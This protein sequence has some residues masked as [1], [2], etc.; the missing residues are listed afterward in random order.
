[1]FI[2]S[3]NIYIKTSFFSTIRLEYFNLQAGKRASIS[4]NTFNNIA[5]YKAKKSAVVTIGTFDGVHHGH[6]KILKRV[7]EIAQEQSLTSILL[8]FFPHPRMVLQPD[9]NLQ[10]IN[11]I[12][13]RQQLI[14]TNGIENIITHPFSPEFART[15]AHDY[16]KDILVDQLNAAVVVIGYDH[17]FGRNRAASIN[18]LEEYGKEYGFEVIQISK[19]DVEE[20]TVSSTKIRNAIEAGDMETT[21]NYL[22]RPF[23]IQ[24]SIVQGKA[25]GRTIN[26]PTANLKIAETYK[27]SPKNGV[28]ITSSIINN[29]RVYG[30]TNIG[31]NP[32]VTDGT[33]KTI[34]THYLNYTGDL[35]NT[36]MQL[37]FHK[38]LR[39]ELKFSSIEELKA[40]M[41]QD[42]LNTQT[43]VQQMG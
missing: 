33:K 41:K 9:S 10:L 14:A 6:Q 16:V 27:L 35:Y 37:F 7:T 25:L 34:E 2:A 22:N 13:E 38:R 26:Y 15:N 19:K 32:T 4:L 39:D 5:S 28:Y 36:Q 21:F 29:Q 18:E 12:E 11:T 17:R 23:S 40:A 30:M 3:T 24:G 1:M 42:E 20:V 31:V 43:Y 8:T